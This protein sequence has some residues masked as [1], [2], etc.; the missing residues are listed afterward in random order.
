MGSMI[1]PNKLLKNVFPLVLGLSFPAMAY[2]IV[3]DDIAFKP[4]EPVQ[5]ADPITIATTDMSVNASPSESET[6]TNELISQ[7]A[8]NTEIQQSFKESPEKPQCKSLWRKNITFT[9]MPRLYPT[10]SNAGNFYQAETYIPQLLARELTKSIGTGNHFIQQTISENLDAE[11]KRR[12]AQQIALKEGTQFVLQGEIL[13]MSMRDPTTVYS[14][15]FVQSL[16]NYFTD[17]TFIKFVDSRDRVFALHLVLRDGFTGEVVFDQSYSTSGIWKNPAPIGFSSPDLW[18]SHYGR[19]IEK[20][21][22][23]ASK[24]LA[25]N[26]KC[27]PY[28]AR[29]EVAPGQTELLLEGGANNGLHSGDQLKLYQMVVIASPGRYDSYQTR[30]IKRDIHLQLKEVYPSHSLALMQGDYMLNGQYLAVGE[31]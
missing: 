5:S 1:W 7:Q 9:A 11:Q 4:A 31:E 14:P 16:R 21:L 19:R 8:T 22:H 26:L 12:T 24:Q 27:Q 30:L 18:K 25:N 17:I 20:L 15:G 10:Q 2:Q 6:A 28:M 13:D 29:I 3:P 23:K